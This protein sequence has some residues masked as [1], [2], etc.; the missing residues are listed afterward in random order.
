MSYIVEK[1]ILIC[2]SV[3]WKMNDD[4]QISKFIKMLSK[5]ATIIHGNCPGV[6]QIAHYH[7]VL[8]GLKTEK[9]IPNFDKY[10]N[11]A[12]FIRN[13]EMIDKGK[14]DLVIGIENEK[15]KIT[16]ELKILQRACDR[17]IRVM[18]LSL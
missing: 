17:G 9:F 11:L 6:A 12:L 15:Y 5:D 4:S 3:H 2:G 13:N 8:N 16:G 1:R 14:P 10:G 7:A 18:W